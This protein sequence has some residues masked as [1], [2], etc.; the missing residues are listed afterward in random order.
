[1]NLPEFLL[2]NLRLASWPQPL[3]KPVVLGL[4]K[5]KSLTSLPFTT[6]YH[7][8]RFDGDAA[9]MIDYHVLSRGAF[10]P[11]LT[12]LIGHW[13][14]VHPPGLFLDV[15]A[16][17]GIHTLANAGKF[18]KVIAVEPYPPVADRLRRALTNN[19]IDNV[20]VIETALADHIGSAVFHAPTSANLGT[21]RILPEADAAKTDGTLTVH[22]R[23]GDDLLAGESLAL[24]LV[25]IDTEGAEAAV[26]TGLRER[27]RTDR[28]L[29]IFELL[30]ASADAAEALRRRFPEKYRFF[31]LRG[32]RKNHAT[33]A[34]WSAGSGDIVAVPEEKSGMLGDRTT[35]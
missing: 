5:R 35:S 24:A 27:L 17:V 33:L 26:L 9:N 18:A 10:E 4:I 20:D 19:G 25:K 7:G 28:P 21:G 8:M 14:G 31:I 13:G 34:Q 3:R 12:G 16:N 6:R 32:V 11:G 15:G 23:T 1:M 29:V 2:R 30:D 22:T